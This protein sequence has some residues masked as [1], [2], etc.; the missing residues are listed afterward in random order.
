MVTS[1]SPTP[2]QRLV[3]MSAYAATALVILTVL[4]AP[5]ALTIAVT[6]ASAGL[7]LLSQVLHLSKRRRPAIFRLLAFVLGVVCLG[8]G[9]GLLVNSPDSSREFTSKGTACR[10]DKCQVEYSSVIGTGTAQ[11][12]VGAVQAFLPGG[13]ASSST[14]VVTDVDGGLLW[15]RGFNPGY[16]VIGLDTDVTGHIFARF[17]V[18]NHSTIVWVIALSDAG[19]N[20]FG[21]VGGSLPV[22]D[23]SETDVAGRRDLTGFRT[24]WPANTAPDSLVDVFRWNSVDYEFVGCRKHARTGPGNY[25]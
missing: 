15:S 9:S 21:T 16:G 11:V 12:N 3:A 22:D 23:Y 25:L 5:Q 20:D 18:T 19:V 7:T 8:L 6:I 4:K 10:V 1:V 13:G 17:A 2:G 24:G 14:L